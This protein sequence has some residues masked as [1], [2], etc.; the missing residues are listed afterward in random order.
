[1]FSTRL[2][3]QF[4]AVAEELHFGRA[5]ARVHMAQSP[6]SQAIRKL[7]ESLG[8]RLFIR[9]KRSV[10]LTEA[11]KV[12]LR[13]ALSMLRAQDAAV[14]MVRHA[15]NF[16]SGGL[17]IG[18]VGNVAYQIV[19]QLLRKFRRMHPTV[20][21]DIVEMLTRDQVRNLAAGQLDAGIV[22]LPIQDTVGLNI[23]VIETDRFIV[24]LPADHGMAGRSSIVLSDL[25]NECFVAYS[26]DRVPVL[27]AAGAAAC[28]AEGFYPNIVCQAW[29]ASSILSFVAAGVGVALIPSHLAVFAHEGVVYRPLSAGSSN[30]ELEIAVIWRDG[31]TSPALEAFLQTMK[32]G[33]RGK[34]QPGRLRI[35]SGA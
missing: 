32:E 24:A 14:A 2:L 28:L 20:H 5:A 1:M 23:R 11:G 8:A 29:Q 35:R 4:I 26:N 13:Q 7:E 15:Q 17:A 21:L 9:T 12:F 30:A 31:D 33:R 6:L 10:T 25:R 19:P 3:M 22:R 16:G 34:R 18:F 27:H